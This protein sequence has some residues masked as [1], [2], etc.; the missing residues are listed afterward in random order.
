METSYEKESQVFVYSWVRFNLW[1][2]DNGQ[3]KLHIT[4]G[5]DQAQLE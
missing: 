3:T 2:Y 5:G 4:M 1:E